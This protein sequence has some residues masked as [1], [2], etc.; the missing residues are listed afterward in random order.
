M[1]CAER[2]DGAPRAT[3]EQTVNDGVTDPIRPRARGQTS[4]QPERIAR[5]PYPCNSPLARAPFKNREDDRVHVH[6][7]MPIDVIELQS[8]G[9]EPRKL[10]RH[11]CFQLRLQLPLKEEFHARGYG[12][13][14]EL[15]LLVH[16]AGNL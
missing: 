12:I 14:T 15:T 11:L 13:L 6:V 3:R 9:A 2:R 5:E 1:L 8:R 7:E 10:F 16:Q 4:I